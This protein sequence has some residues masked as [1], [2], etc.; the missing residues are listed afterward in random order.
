[1]PRLVMIR[2]RL[3]TKAFAIEAIIVIKLGIIGH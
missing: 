2:L 1:M 3:Q